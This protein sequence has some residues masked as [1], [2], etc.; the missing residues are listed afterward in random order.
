LPRWPRAHLIVEES[1][2]IH[3]RLLSGDVAIKF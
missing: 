1:R 2:Q 3:P